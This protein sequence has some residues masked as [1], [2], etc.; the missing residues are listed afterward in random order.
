LINKL[1][2]ASARIYF[3]GY[4][5]LTWAPDYKDFDPELSYGGDNPDNTSGQSY[6]LQ[7]IVTFGISVTF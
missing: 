5:L 3:S 2:I 7:R 6:P 4:N 1:N